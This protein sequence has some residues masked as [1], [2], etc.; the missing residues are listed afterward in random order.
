MSTDP[1]TQRRL[2]RGG[3]GQF[4]P[5]PQPMMSMTSKVLGRTIALWFLFGASQG[6]FIGFAF[7]FLGVLLGWW[8]A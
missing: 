2:V 6:F 4:M 7:C 3:P 1:F 8:H 5:V